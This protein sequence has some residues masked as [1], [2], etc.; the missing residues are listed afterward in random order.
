MR[1]IYTIFILLSIQMTGFAQLGTQRIETAHFN[2]I[3]ASPD[4]VYFDMK[5][6]EFDLRNTFERIPVDRIVS[7]SL[8]YTQYR[9]SDRFDQLELNTNRVDR[10]LK[11][12]PALK[13]NPEI[14]WFWVA[15]TGCDNPSDCRDFFHGFE[16]QLRSEVSE[17]LMENESKLLDLY[18]DYYLSGET[19]T[20]KLDSIAAVA[21]SPISKKCDTVYVEIGYYKSRYGRLRA[22]RNRKNARYH[23]V[24]QIRRKVITV[25]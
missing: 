13:N 6:N 17:A 4:F 12:F 23:F 25:N 18:K 16:V 20:E 8:V 5:F 24:R 3:I 9:L 15:Q 22:N 11:A 1:I 7:V 14:K 10:L 2:K 19:A 21:G